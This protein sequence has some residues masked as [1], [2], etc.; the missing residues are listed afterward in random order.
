M[1]YLFS[2][3]LH[4]HKR[5]F[6]SLIEYV[7]SNASE[8]YYNEDHKDLCSLKGNYRD[9][10][11]LIE[12]L[13]PVI[14]KLTKNEMFNYTHKGINLYS[15]S[16]SEILCF[17]STFDKFSDFSNNFSAEEEFGWLYNNFYEDLIYNLAFACFWIDFWEVKFSKLPL[18]H[19]VI[20]FS[21][22]TIYSKTLL[23]L[24]V[25]RPSKTYVAE[26]FFTGNEYYL[27]RKNTHTS[28]NSDLKYNTYL[29]SLSFTSLHEF[30]RERIKAHNK[31]RLAK[32][33]NVSQPN[34]KKLDFF[35]G[36]K[37]ILIIGQVVNDFSVLENKHGVRNTLSFYK[38]LIINTLEKTDEN[39]V[40]KCHPWERHNVNLKRPK[41]L[42]FLEAWI[43]DL[44]SYYRDR[45]V[46][47]EDFNIKQLLS[48]SLFMV[49]LCSQAAL[50]AA[51]LGYKPV[52]IGNAFYGGK[53]F[54]YDMNDV[55][56]FIRQYNMGRIGGRLSVDEF[57]K[58]EVFMTKALQK[59]LVSVHKSGHM[60][61]RDIFSEIKPIN[62]VQQEQNVEKSVSSI[63][64]ANELGKKDKIIR[65]KKLWRKLVTNPQGYF[66][67][68]KHKFL[69]P[70]QFFF[71]G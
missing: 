51:Y 9:H 28:N 66:K 53:G 20:V 54:T 3:S 18:I 41:T 5:N 70:L 43:S 23:M 12:S 21:G 11:H 36:R 61:L 59:H 58:Y 26:T 47:T 39:I 19:N 45:V 46:I 34:F 56:E 16:R 25:K 30:E 69:R 71:K 49:T 48:Q 15:A 67:D 27:E 38:E 10:L 14:A 17:I 42:E 22:S 31:I 68:S 55:D 7:E 57:Y 2:D 64:V 4:F 6:K 62:L 37:F 44:P 50:E 24:C 35:S 52:Q 65:R 32:N 60:T 1:R 63:N 33:K 29:K 13:Y 40:F 8:Y